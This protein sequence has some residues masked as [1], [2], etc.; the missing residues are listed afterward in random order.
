M[1]RE[2]ANYQPHNAY[3]TAEQTINPVEQSS[4]KVVGKAD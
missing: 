2:T 1:E 3:E 4:R